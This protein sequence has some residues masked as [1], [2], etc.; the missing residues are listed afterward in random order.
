MSY[1]VS[2]SF[3]IKNGT[4]HDYRMIYEKLDK[5]G[6]KRSIMSSDNKLYNIPT[7]TTVVGE[8]SGENCAKI[9]DDLSTKVKKIYETLGLKGEFI[10]VVGGDWAWAIRYT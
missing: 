8:F 3:D 7:T 2:V 6:F 9:R 10:L 4:P 1:L 5:I